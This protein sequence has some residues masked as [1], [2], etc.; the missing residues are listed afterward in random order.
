MKTIKYTLAGFLLTLGSSVTLAD[1]T[2]YTANITVLNSNLVKLRN[3]NLDN[4]SSP[5]ILSGRVTRSYLS[6]DI[7]PGFINADIIG[8]DGSIIENQQWA[9]EYLY[10]GDNSI[11][12]GFEFLLSSPPTLIKEIK[13]SHQGS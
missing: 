13:L 5:S 11:F 12:S 4:T 1:N 7:D 3:I 8:K 9:L 6:R 2:N 10:D